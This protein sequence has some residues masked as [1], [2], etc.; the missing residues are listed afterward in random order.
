MRQFFI[1]GNGETRCDLTIHT[2]DSPELVAQNQHPFVMKARA[3]QTL[4]LVQQLIGVPAAT[5]AFRHTRNGTAILSISS[6]DRNIDRNEGSY[7]NGAFLT[8][9][10]GNLWQFDTYT[11]ENSKHVLNFSAVIDSNGFLQGDGVIN[12]FLGG[13]TKLC[14]ERDQDYI[15]EYLNELFQVISSKRYGEV[16]WDEISR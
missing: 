9:K 14:R 5:H 16:F 7:R 12:F 2:Y 3:S 13:L 15:D 10:S 11:I 4:S 8:K 1:P 6:R